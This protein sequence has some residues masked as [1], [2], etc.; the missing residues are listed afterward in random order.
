MPSRG[1]GDLTSNI[2]VIHAKIKCFE[3]ALQVIARSNTTNK[4]PSIHQSESSYERGGK[5]AQAEEL[6]RLQQVM[7]QEQRIKIGIKIGMWA[8][9]PTRVAKI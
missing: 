3:W 9:V 2:P 6:R 5:G 8:N 4:W 1:G 7:Q